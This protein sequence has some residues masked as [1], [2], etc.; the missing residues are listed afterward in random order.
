MAIVFASGGTGGHLI[1]A[2]A[3]ASKLPQ[4]PKFIV[5]SKPIDEKLM[6]KNNFEYLILPLKAKNGFLDWLKS[7]MLTLKFFVQVRPKVVVGFGGFV[8]VIPVIL[9]KV[10]GAKS[11]IFEAE[12]ALGR[13]NKLLQ[14]FVDAILTVSNAITHQKA[15]MIGYP[16]R[17]EFL[18]FDW[19]QKSGWDGIIFIQ[20]GSQGSE[21]FDLRIASVLSK[22][23][24]VTKIYHQCRN[25]NREQVVKV[26]Q[27]SG[28]EFVVESFFDR[29]WELYNIS[30]LVVIRCGAGSIYETLFSGK[31]YIAV[32][33]PHSTNDHQM[34]NAQFLNQINPSGVVLSQ[35]DPLFDLK[36]IDFVANVAS[37]NIKL[38]VNHEVVR[39][40]TDGVNK[41]INFLRKYD[42]LNE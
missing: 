7:F 2:L 21:F 5:S 31:P 33:Y 8:S 41:F 19:S 18:T 6:S 27:K 34:R 32:P 16:I 22:I 23:D 17:S 4:P 40:L 37:G 36:L 42:V 12:L 38:Q 1:P 20:G 13:A 25:E 29:P 28:K 10:F 30:D 3:I 11:F 24:S 9:A 14:Y 15:V 26:Y 39:N 35:E